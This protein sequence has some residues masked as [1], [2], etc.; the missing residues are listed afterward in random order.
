MMRIAPRSRPASAFLAFLALPL[1][2][3]SGPAHP[4]GSPAASTSNGPVMAKMTMRG[5]MMDGGMMRGGMMASGMEDMRPIH[6]L[7]AS[8][9]SIERTVVD[10]PNGV[11]TVTVSDDPR[12]TQLI[13][14]HV[15]QMRDRYDRGQPIRA[16]DPLFR[17]LFEHR[18]EAQ[19]IIRDIPG[20]V[21]VLHT[22][23]NPQVVR[24]IRQH[25]RHFVDEV[26]DRGM[27]GAMGPTPLPQGYR[28]R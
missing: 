23:A 11:R 28:E 3:C 6:A 18:D 9:E 1:L 27:A 17:E 7:L 24:L 13:R 14:T 26:V 15:R 16:M 25:A 2:A 21:E 22:S 4:G 20:G 8:H 12:V 10:L 5:R 19:L